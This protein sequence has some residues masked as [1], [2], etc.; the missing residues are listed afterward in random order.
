MRCPRGGW[1]WGEWIALTTSPIN[2]GP[3]NNPTNQE[4]ISFTLECD[5]PMTS[6]RFSFCRGESLMPHYIWH[7]NLSLI[8]SGEKAKKRYCRLPHYHDEARK[9]LFIFLLCVR[10]LFL[11]FR[12]AGI[13]GPASSDTGTGCWRSN[14]CV[15]FIWLSLHGLS[16]SSRVITV[17]GFWIV[18]VSTESH[19]KVSLWLS[20]SS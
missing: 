6:I 18:I 10:C 8:T 2:Y 11:A 16:I 5:Y 15:F 12:L 3:N 17:N 7:G 9:E 1:M 20:I 4:A 13:Y 14:W 19:W